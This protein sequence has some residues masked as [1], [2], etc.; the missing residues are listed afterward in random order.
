M[1]RYPRTFFCRQRFETRRVD[2]VPGA[3]RA[4]L[5]RID[6]GSRVAHGTPVA[7]AVGS[8]GIANLAAIVHALVAELRALGAEPFVVPAMGSHGGATSEGQRRVLET[9]GVH[10]DAVGAPIRASME[11]LC[12][13]TTAD[14]VPVHV[15]RTASEAGGLLLVN[16]V[17]PHTSFAA[18]IESGLVKMAMIG[19]GNHEGAVACH[20]AMLTHSFDRLVDTVW[21]LV[22]ARLP[23]VA[24]L[25]LVENAYDET[26]TV[27][28]ML[29]DAFCAREAV[30]LERARQWMPRLPLDAIDV[31]VV[32]ETGKDVSGLGMDPNVTGRKPVRTPGLPT[33]T[34]L[35]ARDLTPASHGN[36]HGIGLA[37]FTT[38]RLV[39]AIDARAMALNALAAGNPQASRIP[40]AFDTDREAIDAAL[41][42]VGLARAEDVRLVRIRNTLRLDV[43]EISEACL[44]DLAGREDVERLSV[45][46]EI[47]FD[48]NGNLTPLPA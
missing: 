23:I 8:R 39:R 40:L 15:G 27:E 6:L 42:T 41:A 11:T 14:G 16:R 47:T 33:V 46:R 19:L 44:P 20:R 21:P 22:R 28:A 5:R 18:R 31:L 13:G 17:K 2:D 12:V 10:E 24:G 3:V 38:T 35:I 45:P 48:R 4:E 30:L 36:A 32:D 43:V 1:M 9:Y 34:R 26:A 7:I 37:D 29:P 25:A